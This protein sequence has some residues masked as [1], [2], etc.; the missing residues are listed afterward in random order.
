MND[1]TKMTLNHTG[2]L[3]IG[4]YPN[5]KLDVNGN[6]RMENEI[7]FKNNT[8]MK[9][10]V[11]G[12]AAT[13]TNYYSRIDDYEGNL[14]IMTDDKMYFTDINSANGLPTG[15]A[16]FLNV[17]SKQL[18]INT[19]QPASGF[20][21][22]VKGKAIMEEIKVEAAPWPDYVF[23]TDYALPTLSETE[24]YIKENHRLPNMPSAEEVAENGIALGEMNRLVV[25]K[26]EELTLY[27]I[28]LKKEIKQLKSENQELKKEIS[29]LKKEEIRTE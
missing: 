16:M 20:H 14:R 27:V 17:D 26:V 18:A 22:T 28:D 2:N 9:G 12:D 5:A 4:I 29:S 6:A 21:L 24:T 8:Q 13:W 7:R 1:A 15:T 3:G 25:E 10:L 19:D 11:W 23:A